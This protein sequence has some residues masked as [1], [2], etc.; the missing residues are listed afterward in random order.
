MSLSGILA[1][2]IPP[3]V[4]G[5]LAEGPERC[6]GYTPYHE[7]PLI[8][9]PFS[10]IG[11]ANRAGQSALLPWAS[12][13]RNVTLSRQA[14]CAP[15]DTRVAAAAEIHALSEW[16]AGGLLKGEQ[17]LF[18]G[19]WTKAAG[20]KVW[21]W[22]YLLRVTCLSLSWVRIRSA[23]LIIMPWLTLTQLSPRVLRG[24]CFL[25]RLK[26]EKRESVPVNSGVQ[27]A[28]RINL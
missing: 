9:N 28:H 3:R 4:L 17:S 19:Q 14:N 23:V 27:H 18:V 15:R 26:K 13:Q 11:V 24:W 1:L 12:S 7:Q 16:S 8:I 22:P 20:R 2:W 10:Q 6:L 5:W 21:F 25:P